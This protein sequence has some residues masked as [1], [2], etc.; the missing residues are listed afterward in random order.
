MALAL[1]ALGG[2][3]AIVEA[4]RRRLDGL[5]PGSRRA[6]TL[7]ALVLGGV[8][9][10]WYGKRVVNDVVFHREVYRHEVR[11][12]EAL[13]ASAAA[14]L[15]EETQSTARVLSGYTGLG[16]VGGRCGRYVKDIGAL[17]NPDIFPYLEGT[18]PL[19]KERW[20]RTLRY[21][22]D[23]NLTYYVTDPD[24]DAFPANATEVKGVWD[25][26]D[27]TLAAATPDIHPSRVAI[28]RMEIAILQ[29]GKTG[30]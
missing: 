14:W 13:R 16:V 21:M 18:R 7:A 8:L 27:S 9:V 29:R 20:Q 19:T 25:T 22:A 5:S 10:L 17:I 26:A 23:K 15:R 3:E 11:R 4:A 30:E 24:V 2:A 6:A 12:N 28:Y 1:F